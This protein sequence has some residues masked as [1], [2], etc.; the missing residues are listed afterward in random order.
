MPPPI[1]D[2]KARQITVG[3]FTFVPLPSS[4]Q[5]H[6]DSFLE[7][8]RKRRKFVSNV[9]NSTPSHTFDDDSNDDVIFDST[10]R[11]LIPPYSNDS[12]I[13]SKRFNMLQR[14]HITMSRKPSTSEISSENITPL[15][16]MTQV[17]YHQFT[18]RDT[19]MLLKAL[20]D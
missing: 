5:E 17:N 18:K 2:E 7:S 16:W 1:K 9:G 3:Q 14:E 6:E 4:L 10:M 11:D 13:E 15:N 20:F 8:S 19:D 12:K